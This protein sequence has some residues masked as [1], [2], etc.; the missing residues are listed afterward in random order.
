[1]LNL[2]ALYLA[3]QFVNVK[4]Q[5]LRVGRGVSGLGFCEQRMSHG[6]RLAFCF[7]M[8]GLSLW[9]GSA[10][11]AQTTTGSVVG[12]V[13]DATSASVASATVTLVNTDTSEKKTAQTD[14]NGAYQFLNLLPGNYR[15][16]VEKSGFKRF[17]RNGLQ[18]TVQGA[19]RVDI[20]LPVGDVTE[21]IDI[22]TDSP[23]IDTQSASVSA[24]VEG[25]TVNELPLN[26]RNTMN[27]LSTVAGVIPQGSSQGA[28]GG[29][30]AGGQ[31]TNDFGWGN[32]QIGGGMA[33]QSAFFLDGVTLNGPWSN[34]IGI[35]PTQDSVQEFRVVSNSVS[36]DFG[37]LMGG[38]VN[39]TTKAGTNQF[40]GTLYEYLRNTVLNANFFFNNRTGQPR[41]P[42]KQNQYGAA[43][44]GPILHD[45][46][47]FFFS[48]EGFSIRQA[49]P[50]LTTVPTA[51]MKAGDFTGLA[52]LY[53]PLTTCGQFGNPACSTDSTGK[54]IITRKTFA[55]QNAT[56]ANVIPAN[57]I[58]PTAKALLNLYA[59]PNLPGTGSNYAANGP[60]GSNQNEY[61]GRID[62][63]LSAKQRLFGRYSYWKW[64]YAIL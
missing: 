42:V 64:K 26:G 34:T 27:L 63:S 49:I 35:V 61:V 5:T 15:V 55:S 13:T 58:D 25:R 32:I 11:S 18:V 59:A 48:W 51:A 53:D 6:I 20:P 21:S 3:L 29:N 9:S 8:F 23:L 56:G 22:S 33:G 16:E 31:F 36:P 28:T 60:T 57:R 2:K 24:V 12:V 38:A 62:H 37:A 19:V 14:S 1:M 50:L 43:I 7:A 40:H 46:T 47:F 41:P 30:Q 4:V 10:L 39:I 17:V 45:K 54:A 52:L 44:G